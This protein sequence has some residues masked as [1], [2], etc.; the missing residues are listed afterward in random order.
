MEP[1]NS[2]GKNGIKERLGIFHNIG[3]I[4]TGFSFHGNF[5]RGYP[6]DLGAGDFP[7]GN[8]VTIPNKMQVFLGI[9]RA[10]SLEF[11]SY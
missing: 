2:D 10:I 6:G 7:A 5:R 1:P 3:N 11:I 9:P 8:D 4:P